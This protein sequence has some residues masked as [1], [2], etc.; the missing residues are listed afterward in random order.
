MPAEST[1]RCVRSRPIKADRDD[2]GLTAR[3]ATSGSIDQ[4]DL[5]AK[6]TV[7]IDRG[8]CIHLCFAHG[9][10]LEGRS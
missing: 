9:E 8:G 6:V 5:W 3:P 2:V 1:M 4:I 7:K 10:P